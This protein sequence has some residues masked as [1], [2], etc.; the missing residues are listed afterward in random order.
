MMFHDPQFWTLVSFVLFAAVAA[1]PLWNQAKKT[2]DARIHKIET[3][4]KHLEDVLKETTT[5]FQSEKRRARSIQ[6]EVKILLNNAHQEA[7]RLKASLE[8]DLERDLNDLEKVTL[9]RFEE[10]KER[11]INQ[12]KERAIKISKDTT[13]QILKEALSPAVQEKL[14]NNQ[15]KFLSQKK[16]R[17]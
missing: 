3:N 5:T 15:I 16:P 11:T 2:L 10:K 9:K 13:L 1:R 12:V 7:L 17:G 6:R 8:A 4:L 14:I